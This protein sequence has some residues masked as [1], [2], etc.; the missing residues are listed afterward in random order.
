MRPLPGAK[1]MPYFRLK[2]FKLQ[3]CRPIILG[4]K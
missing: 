2:I 3:A 1:P 4:L